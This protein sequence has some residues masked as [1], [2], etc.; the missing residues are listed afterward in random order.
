M[1]FKNGYTLSVQFG[2]DSYCHNRDLTI[3]FPTNEQE[4]AAGEKGS[5]TAEVAIICPSGELYPIVTYNNV[6]GFTTTDELV[7]V[8]NNISELGAL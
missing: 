8:I 6:Q 2:P 4:R 5:E 3:N 7:E 1:K